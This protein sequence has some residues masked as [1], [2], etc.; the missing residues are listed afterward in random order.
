MWRI[1]RGAHI[2]NSDEP[3][4]GGSGVGPDQECSARTGST[5]FGKEAFLVITKYVRI[6]VKEAEMY[7]HSLALIF[8]VFLVL[9]ERF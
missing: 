3:K 4:S 8:F 6:P 5:C 1:R 9:C 7:L 2:G